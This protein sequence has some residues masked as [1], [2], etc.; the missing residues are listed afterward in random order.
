MP[1]SVET[2]G[3]CL[4][5]AVTSQIGYGAKLPDIGSLTIVHS[6]AAQGPSNLSDEKVNILPDE[7]IARASNPHLLRPSAAT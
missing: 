4:N 6:F 2:R 7:F 5:P 3:T 1:V